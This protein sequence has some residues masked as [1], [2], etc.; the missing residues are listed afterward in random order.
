MTRGNPDSGRGFSLVAGT[1]LLALSGCAGAFAPRDAAPCAETGCVTV[2]IADADTLRP[3]PRPD[4]EDATGD[5]ASA[6]PPGAAI[7]GGASASGRRLGRTVAS[8]GDVRQPGLWLRTPL[9]TQERAGFVTHPA[10]GR[11]VRVRLL[12]R[13]APAGSGSQISLA[14]LQALGLPLTGLAELDVS[15]LPD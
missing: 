5:A 15:V 8:L 11:S 2:R 14:A 10:T 6:E 9:V 13:D 3:R 4:R 7:A 1:A 12:A